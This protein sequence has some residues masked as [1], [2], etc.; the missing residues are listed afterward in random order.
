MGPIEILIT[1]VDD[2]ANITISVASMATRDLLNSG[3]DRLIQSLEDAGM[4]MGSFDINHQDQS[5]SDDSEFSG[6]QS[7]QGYQ[8]ELS[9][10]EVVVENIS[11]I[12]SYA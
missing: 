7:A 12:D 11:L 5:S 3:S 10:D 4:E 9:I 2:V 1:K 6:S 8:D